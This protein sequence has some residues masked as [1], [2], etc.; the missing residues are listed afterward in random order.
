MARLVVAETKAL[1]D[2]VDRTEAQVSEESAHQEQSM[3]DEKAEKTQAATEIS[4]PPAHQQND[5]PPNNEPIESGLSVA[6]ENFE[7]SNQSSDNRLK[8][9]FKVKNTS[10]NSQRISGHVIVVLKGKDTNWLPIPWM[11]LVDGRPTGKSRGHSFGIN[12]FKTMRLSTRA[13]KSPEKFDTATIF[14]LTR[15]GELLLE[16]EYPV[17]LPPNGPVENKPAASL[18]AVP[19]ESAPASSPAAPSAE[20]PPATQILGLPPT[21]ASTK[22]PTATD[23]E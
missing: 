22:I 23:A 12:Y 13:P 14:V 7:M 17:Q 1:P 11:S 4:Q 15:Q 2:S 8:V 3:S 19:V 16:K 5:S 20:T 9:M 6:V 10:P 18:P 21:D